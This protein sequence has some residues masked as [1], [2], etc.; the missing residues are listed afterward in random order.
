MKQKIE[1]SISH[2]QPLYVQ[3]Y[4]SFLLLFSTISFF[5]VSILFT[6]VI[7]GSETVS[8]K[9]GAYDNHPKIFVDNN[10]VSG[11]W[12]EILRYIAKKENWKTEYIRGTWSEGLDRLKKKE[13]DIM[14]D[15]AFTEKRDK[16]YT[17]S[18]DP[19]LMSW[20]RLYVNRDNADIR[21]IQDLE[22]KKIAALKG[23]VNLEG[24][25]GLREILHGFNIHCTLTELDNYIEVFKA[26]DEN[27]VD[28]G[29]TNRNFGNKNEPNYNVKRTAIIFHPVNIQFAFPKHSQLT[30]LLAKAINFHMGKLLA[31]EES[32]YYQLLKK[33]RNSIPQQ[34]GINNIK[35]NWLIN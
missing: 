33:Y 25:G 7:A 24:A 19:V 18:K 13:I 8:V 27:R 21:S 35:N 34:I 32:L 10:K 2:P 5:V 20:T 30:P 15:V 3:K 12:P 22:N 14:P 17:F 11:F 29:V 1:S 26:I 23:S 16:L 28:A 9:I 6:N 31:D 4:I